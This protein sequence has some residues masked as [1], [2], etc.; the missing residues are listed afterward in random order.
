MGNRQS[1]SVKEENKRKVIETLFSHND[2]TRQGIIEK[3]GLAAST[4]SG[5]T[6][7]LI[8]Q[9][10]IRKIGSVANMGMGRKIDIL[11]R[12][13]DYDSVV[14][15]SLTKENCEI[16]LV[17]FGL[18]TIAE[19]SLP[20]DIVPDDSGSQRLIDAIGDFLRKQSGR[21]VSAVSLALPHHPYSWERIRKELQRGLPLPFLMLNNVEAMAL[22]D[23]YRTRRG[24]E[25]GTLFYVFVGPGIGSALIIDGHLHRGMNGWASDLGHI[26]IKDGGELC[27]C[28]RKGCLETVA[29]ENS[30]RAEMEKL[31]G[32]RLDS[33]N[34]L[35]DAITKGFEERNQSV[36][37]ILD[38]AA[39]YLAEGL[40]T[41]ISL[42]DPSRIVIISSLNRIR[43]YYSSLIEEK[44]YER[45]T[46]RSP[47][48]VQ[49]DYE[50]FERSSGVT[51]AALYA[52]LCLNTHPGRLLKPLQPQKP[53]LLTGS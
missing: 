35:I 44:L 50:D 1:I 29:S 48:S 49:R 5:I 41:I 38:S 45:F 40:H 23:H 2:I 4:I 31:T 32:E 46:S 15:V 36:I 39:D 25:E 7:D 28:G 33:P 13:P 34:T 9:G 43:P 16:S 17:D 27:R 24:E 47:F 26:H 37:E 53:P 19:E 42:L 51:G 11:T 14:S 21:K 20:V 8:H 12:V 18:N 6:A 10:M 22:S 30:L 3:T 52:F